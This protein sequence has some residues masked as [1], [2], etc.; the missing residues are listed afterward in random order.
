ME[1]GPKLLALNKMRIGEILNHV[2]QKFRIRNNRGF[3]KPKSP[4]P[5]YDKIWFPTP[6]KR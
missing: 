6:E 1:N 5:E 4:P 2:N 3:R